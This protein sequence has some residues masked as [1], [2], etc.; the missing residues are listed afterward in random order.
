MRSWSGW[1]S[2]PCRPAIPNGRR[3]PRCG[4]AVAC[5]WAQ[6][7]PEGGSRAGLVLPDGCT[8]LV[9]EQG[10]GAFVAGPDT[11][12]VA[13]TMAAGTVIARRPLPALG[14]RSRARD[15]AQRTPRPA[16]RPRRPAA[17]RGEATGRRARPGGRRGPGAGRDRCPGRRRRAGP[18][19][20]LGRSPAARPVRAGRGR[21]GRGRAQPAPVAPPLPGRGRLRPEDAAAGAAIPRGS[22]RASTPARWPWTW[23]PSRPR[24]A[25]PTRP[26]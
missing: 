16:R 14:G 10:R 20:D 7:T 17:G 11:G 23:P 13:T 9:W 22:S 3:P 19:R 21:R 18:R 2:E 5:L 12:P 8:D 26:T 1:M 4:D 6:V 15:P 25:T 24:R